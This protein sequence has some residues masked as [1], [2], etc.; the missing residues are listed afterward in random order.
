MALTTAEVPLGELIRLAFP[1]GIPLPPASFRDRPVRWV[2]VAGAGVV[3][4]GGDLVLCGDRVPSRQ[5]LVAWKAERDCRP[6][7]ASER[8]CPRRH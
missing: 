5:E 1:P 8:V 4:E 3:P 7:L 6:G 2:L